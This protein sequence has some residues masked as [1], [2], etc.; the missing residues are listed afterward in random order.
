MTPKHL[1]KLDHELTLF[2]EEMIVGMGRPERRSA[3]AHDVTGL[4]LDGERK[5]VQ[6]MASRLVKDQAEADAMR[7][8]LQ[9]CVSVS[10]WSE[11]DL[12]RR[13]AVKL[14]RDLPGIE[15]Y[16]VDD[17]GFAKKGKHSVGVA[18][19]YSGTLGRTDNCQVA[20]SL[21]LAGEKGSGCIGF[22]LYLGKEWITDRARRRRVWRNPRVSRRDHPQ[23]AG[24]RRR[25]SWP[26]SHLAAGD[27]AARAKADPRSTGSSTHPVAGR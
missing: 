23:G 25:R 7:Q 8:R 10:R 21:H 11:Q 13:L 6:P 12:F 22:R 4:L 18:R 3:M 5:S 1:K 15:A 9:D 20:T 27:K 26:S 14:D 19:Q 16:V 24:L 2:L 17:T